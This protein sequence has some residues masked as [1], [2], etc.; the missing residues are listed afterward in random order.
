[1]PGKLRWVT[2]YILRFDPDGDWP[3][4]LNCTVQVNPML[5]AFDGTPLQ[6]PVSATL[7]PFTTPPLSMSISAVE[8][9]R[10]NEQT[11]VARNVA[12]NC[13]KL[14]SPPWPAHILVPPPPLPCHKMSALECVPRG[15][16]AAV[17]SH[18]TD[19]PLSQHYPPPPPLSTYT[20]SQLHTA[21]RHASTTH[22]Q[23]RHTRSTNRQTYSTFADSFQS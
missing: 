3:N 23:V 9:R 16:E 1:M 21:R 17:V 13:R 12:R 15:Q 20:S 10:A 7:F 2:T 6:A 22:T 14:L 5:R 11:G 18:G 4:D 19:I 8:S